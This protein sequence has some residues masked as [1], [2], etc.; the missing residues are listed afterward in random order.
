[1]P[2]AGALRAAWYVPGKLFSVN[3]SPPRQ[4]R[5]LFARNERV[6]CVFE[7]NQRAFAMVLVGGTCSL[8]VSA[9]SGMAT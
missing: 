6:V 3:P 8:A 4:V 1:M 7:G 5:G 9:R 2:L